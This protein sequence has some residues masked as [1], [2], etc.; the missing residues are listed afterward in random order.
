M[1]W[2]IYMETWEELKSWTDDIA[3]IHS[4]KILIDLG[5]RRD[6]IKN[7][8]ALTDSEYDKIITQIEKIRN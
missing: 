5:K 1:K 3:L 6:E 8:F 7:E 4:V 2:V